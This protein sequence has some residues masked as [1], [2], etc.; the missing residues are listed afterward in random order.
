MLKVESEVLGK[1]LKDIKEKKILNLC[2]STYEDN[3]CYQ[4]HYFEN[5]IFPLLRRG[6][7]IYNLDIKEGTGIDIVADCQD[8]YMIIDE[9][10]DIVFF[11]NALEHLW[12]PEKAVAEIYRILKL[13]G[14]CYASAPAEGYPYHEDP[15]DTL[16]RLTT[17]QD[18]KRFFVSS[19]WEIFLFKFLN[20]YRDVY[21]RLDTV[22]I[23]GVRKIK[24]RV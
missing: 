15:I 5:L 22:S 2:S 14:V 16:L 3:W 21:H 8:M 10:Y 20:E 7:V 24:N 1:V 6:N 11:F 13:G 17:M 18:W 4:P 23:I 12:E 19:K 9:S